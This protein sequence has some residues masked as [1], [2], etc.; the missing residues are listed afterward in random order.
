MQNCE[1]FVEIPSPQP[2][3]NDPYATSAYLR[4][5]SQ[6]SHSGEAEPS[7]I[8]HEVAHKIEEL[9]VNVGFKLFL[10]SHAFRGGL[11]IL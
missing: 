4:R 8:G 3:Y 1:R 10:E 7:R 5:I 6:P 9:Q 11:L 2:S